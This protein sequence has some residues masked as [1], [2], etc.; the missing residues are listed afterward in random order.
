MKAKESMWDE[1][2]IQKGYTIF[3]SSGGASLM[4]KP[5]GSYTSPNVKPPKKKP[6]KEAMLEMANQTIQEHEDNI[7]TI[8]KSVSLSLN[9]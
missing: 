7:R 9:S 1:I 6:T 3:L 4:L 8:L 2:F 5:H